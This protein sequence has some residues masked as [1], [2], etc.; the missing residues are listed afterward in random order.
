METASGHR[1]RVAATVRRLV[2]KARRGLGHH[3]LNKFPRMLRLGG[4]SKAALEYAKTLA[5]S[6]VSVGNHLKRRNKTTTRL[7]PL[8]FSKL[9]CVDLKYMLESE[10]HRQIAL[11][12]MQCKVFSP[13]WALC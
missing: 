5:V 11:A 3:P 8:Y 6:C 12:E 10:E 1:E 4:A 13:L 2:R 7:R 9:G